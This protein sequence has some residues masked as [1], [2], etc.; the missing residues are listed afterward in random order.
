[1]NREGQ[2]RI[3]A[4]TPNP[5]LDLSGHVNRIVADEK[6]Y[7]ERARLDPGGNAINAARIAKRLGGRPMLLG[8]LG[9]G[10]GSQLQALLKSEG[11]EEQFTKIR[12]TTRTNVTVTND[13]DHKQTRLTFPGPHISR[14]EIRL[15]LSAI[16]KFRAP[17]IV[18]IGG[19]LPAGCSPRFYIDLIDSVSKQGLGVVVDVPAPALKA[20]IRSPSARILLIKPNQTELETLIGKNLRSISA[21]AAAAHQLSRRA[22]IVCVSLADRGALFCVNQETWMAR[23]P[24]IK[25]RGTVGAGDSMVGAIAARLASW[26]LA[27]PED[28]EQATPKQ[29]SDVF[30]WGIAAGAATAAT[31]GTS[32]GHYALIRKLHSKVAIHKIKTN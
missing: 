14:Q 28:I 22:A 26:K 1:M 27:R 9:G 23:A 17:G 5:A 8:F 30:R 11:L 15:L 12:G 19:S 31:E 10:T 4:I 18:L 32:L 6:N 24:R 21:I 7:V 16:S 20:I 25:A 13:H 29:L 3:Y 2:T